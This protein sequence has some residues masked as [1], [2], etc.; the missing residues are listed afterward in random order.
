MSPLSSRLQYWS[1]IVR[2][3]EW[4]SITF[5][6]LL[7]TTYFLLLV[8]G[9][10]YGHNLWN[11]SLMLFFGV[12]CAS[13]AFVLNTLYDSEQDRQAGK[14]YAISHWSRQRIKAVLIVLFGLSVAVLLVYVAGL[15]LTTIAHKGGLVLG[16]A[17]LTYSLAFAYSAPPFRLKE[18]GVWGPLTIA[19]SE[20]ALPQ[21]LLFAGFKHFN[22][23]T[24]WF[25][26]LFLVAGLRMILTH[27]LLDYGNDLAGKVKTFAINVGPNR[28]F[29][30]ISVVILPLEL[31]ILVLTIL[32]ANTQV[33]GT[34]LF[35]VLCLVC[36]YVDDLLQ[37]RL[38]A[39]TLPILFTAPYT[40]YF[41]LLPLFW[42]TLGLYRSGVFF[43]LLVIHIWV[44]HPHWMP[45]WEKLRLC[46]KKIYW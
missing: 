10:P 38:G 42:L 19:T 15:N 37:Q 25:T 39:I 13:F 28:V 18:R 6:P 12:L 22:W 43:V 29:L 7:S 23:G 44:A 34:L 27:Q 17:V 31:V 45:H 1:Q 36:I 26:L 33:S 30:L 41:L 32:F 4:F 8:D 46:C 21:L 2:L 24:V 20:F 3:D 9:K 16:L 14:T 40:F 5:A 11:A 35:S